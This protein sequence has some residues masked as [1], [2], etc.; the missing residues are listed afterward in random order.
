MS[1]IWQKL[2]MAEAAPPSSPFPYSFETRTV[3]S[4]DGFDTIYDNAGIIWGIDDADNVTLSTSNVTLGTYSWKVVGTSI[5]FAW[6]GLT[7]VPAIDLTGLN[8]ISLDVYVETISSGQ[9]IAFSASDGDFIDYLVEYTPVD[10][11]GSYT[12]THDLDLI[13]GSKAN[14]YFEIS[15]T[16]GP[17]VYYL[18]NLRVA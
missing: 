16:S 7:Q 11:T 15:P 3:G 10:G 12:L 1:L 5:L 8:S 14:M 6:G 4:G 18:D 2:M 17:G 9:R 13:T